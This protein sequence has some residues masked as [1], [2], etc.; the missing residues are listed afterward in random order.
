MG[1]DDNA[2]VSVAVL[3]VNYQ[4]YEELERALGSLER[5]LCDDD[6]VIVVDQ[7]SDRERLA[8]VRARHPRATVLAQSDN[9]GFAAGVNLAAGRA[10]AS[11]LLLLN[12]DAVMEAPVIRVLED[13]LD[14]H[15]D[16]GVV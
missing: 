12:P 6:E 16:A 2:S 11:H 14:R 10:S 8:R 4:A 5:F 7:A 1:T 3:I 9:R 15:P 13:W